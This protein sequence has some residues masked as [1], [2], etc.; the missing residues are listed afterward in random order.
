MS[1]GD[2]SKEMGRRQGVT[3][4]V[5]QEQTETSRHCPGGKKK[6]LKLTQLAF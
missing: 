5:E 3:H 2:A 4:A 6:P 1:Q